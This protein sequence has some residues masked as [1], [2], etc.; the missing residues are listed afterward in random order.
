MVKYL[1]LAENLKYTET[2]M[3]CTRENISQNHR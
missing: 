1:I 2:F 3:R